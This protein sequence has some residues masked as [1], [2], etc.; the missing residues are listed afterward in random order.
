MG[1]LHKAGRMRVWGRRVHK[2]G[3]AP[4]E[5]RTVNGIRFDSKYEARYYQSLLARVQSGELR[6]FER[7]VKF[8]LGM[9]PIHYRADFVVEFPDGRQEVHEIKGVRTPAFN[10]VVRFWKQVGPMPMVILTPGRR[11]WASER[12][13][14]QRRQDA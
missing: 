6:G 7:Q 4:V 1:Y 11:R 2:Y 8:E 9:P 3:V 5:E 10:T 12:I 13:E 14:P